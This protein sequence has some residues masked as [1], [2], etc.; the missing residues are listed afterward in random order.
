[1]QESHAD[2]Q[3]YD[4][5][6]RRRLRALSFNLVGLADPLAARV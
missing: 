3:A 5:D 1:M 2:R 6:A 4:D